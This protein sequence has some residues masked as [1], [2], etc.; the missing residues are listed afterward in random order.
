M[1]VY[2]LYDIL[3]HMCIY[4]EGVIFLSLPLSVLGGGQ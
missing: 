1:Q 3:L 4:V 2:N